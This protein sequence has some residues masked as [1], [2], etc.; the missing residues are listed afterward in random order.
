MYNLPLQAFSAAFDIWQGS[1]TCC[2]LH[3]YFSWLP[4]VP[5]LGAAFLHSSQSMQDRALIVINL[6]SCHT[7]TFPMGAWPTRVDDV[8]SE[9]EG[10]LSD[11]RVQKDSLQGMMTMTGVRPDMCKV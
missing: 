10:C 6:A 8:Q 11:N 3:Y 2:H 9:F 4:T 5:N 7:D 1:T